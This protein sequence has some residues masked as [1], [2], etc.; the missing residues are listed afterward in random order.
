MC[1]ILCATNNFAVNGV[2]TSC[3]GGTTNCNVC[4][5]SG[6]CTSC[7]SNFYPVNGV[8][9]TCI[10]GMTNCNACDNTGACTTCATNYYITSGPFGATCDACTNKLNVVT[11]DGTT[12][13]VLSC[14]AG[15]YLKIPG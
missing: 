10:G 5:S 6:L 14:D 2:C 8:C 13:N 3:I 12:G 7:S 11:C 4:D 1:C 9:T 15:F